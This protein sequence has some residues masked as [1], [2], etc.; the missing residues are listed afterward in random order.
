MARL[1]PG[2][3]ILVRAARGAGLRFFVVDREA[4]PARAVCTLRGAFQEAPEG[5]A[6][7]GLVP[8]SL[9]ITTIKAKLDDFEADLQ[10][11]A[12]QIATLAASYQRRTKEVADAKE[13]LQML[14]TQRALAAS[15]AAQ[16]ATAQSDTSNL[17]YAA[18]QAKTPSGGVVPHQLQQKVQSQADTC[19]ELQQQHEQAMAT[20]AATLS[21]PAA[22]VTPRQQLQPLSAKAAPLQAPPLFAAEAS[23]QPETPQH[24]P[25]SQL[26]FGIEP[27]FSPASADPSRLTGIRLEAPGLPEVQAW[28]SYPLSLRRPVCLDVQGGS[29]ILASALNEAAE[30]RQAALLCADSLLVDAVE[31]LRK[32]Q[33]SILDFGHFA[34]DMSQATH[35]IMGLQDPPAGFHIVLSLKGSLAAAISLCGLLQAGAAAGA[36]SAGAADQAIGTAPQDLV[37]T[38]S[39]SARRASQRRTNPGLR[40]F[41]HLTKEVSAGPEYGLATLT[42]GGRPPPISG[43]R[44]VV[45]AAF[46][47]VKQANI[48]DT[49]SKSPYLLRFQGTSTMGLLWGPCRARIQ[50]AAKSFAAS[51]ASTWDEVHNGRLVLIAEQQADLIAQLLLMIGRLGFMPSQIQA[52]ISVL[53][54]KR[55]Q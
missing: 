12:A 11:T 41:K 42:H 21:A 25:A 49:T 44:S 16:E 19:D 43:M 26:D 10:G 50:C 32:Q 46:L 6:M 53:I 9:Q 15:A 29:D 14:E 23:P 1:G 13:E 39:T 20:Q 5:R 8:S 24:I 27:M 4:E 33:Q 31:P 2:R 22:A 47:E 38:S 36:P 7:R 48:S 55:K 54:T 35:L 3:A 40:G 52:V 28:A 45:P 30:S 17:V 37:K 51:R 18:L 34:Q